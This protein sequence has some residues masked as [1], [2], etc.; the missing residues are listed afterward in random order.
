MKWNSINKGMLLEMNNSCC[1]DIIKY[2][3]NLRPKNGKV[4]T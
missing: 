3:N 1:I 4:D 2:T